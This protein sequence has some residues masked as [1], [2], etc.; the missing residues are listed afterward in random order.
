MK[1]LKGHLRYSATDLASFLACRHL[2]RLDLAAEHGLVEKPRKQDLGTEALVSRGEQH[3]DRVLAELRAQGRKIEDLS[4]APEGFEARS[5]AT[6]DSLRGGAD[7]V[8]QGVLL[9]DDRIG[10]PDFLA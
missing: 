10:L 4:E 5:R 7:V 9:R 8:Y 3:E 2:T 1:L 6:E